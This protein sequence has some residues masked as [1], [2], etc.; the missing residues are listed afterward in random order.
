M[1]T[2]AV[3]AEVLVIG[4]QAVG[5][6]LLGVAA[7]VD[8]RP[9]ASSLDGWQTLVTIG[10]LGFAY[11]L[12][13]IVDRVS[14][15]VLTPIRRLGGRAPRRFGDVRFQ[16]LQADSPLTSFMEYQRSRMRLMRGTAANLAVGIPV[17]NLFLLRTGA[18]PMPNVLVVANAVGL[19]LLV[20]SLYTFLR[21][22]GAQDDWL[23]LV[24]QRGVSVVTEPPQS[25]ASPDEGG[26]A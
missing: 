23:R 15:S 5:L 12:G 21:I 26:W 6:S 20:L 14:D 1:T 22:G 19:T 10:V 18:D 25:A 9:I 4:L 7:F 8:L 16:V 11:V 13:V 17:L 2:T 3:F 24:R